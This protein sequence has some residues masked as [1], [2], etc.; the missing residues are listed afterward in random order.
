MS[1]LIKLPVSETV[2]SC[3]DRHGN[4]ILS[5]VKLV[6]NTVSLEEVAQQQQTKAAEAAEE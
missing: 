5:H 4:E 3:I 6:V 2:K 1:Y